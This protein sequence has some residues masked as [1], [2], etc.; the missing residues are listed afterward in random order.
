MFH[1]IRA[2]P[3]YPYFR[4]DPG[5]GAVYF[6]VSETSH[7]IVLPLPHIGKA[8]SNVVSF[9]HGFVSSLP[10]VVLPFHDIVKASHSNVLCIPALVKP[11]RDIVSTFSSTGQ[12]LIS[13]Q[14]IVIMLRELVVMMR[15]HCGSQTSRRYGTLSCAFHAN[16]HAEFQYN[17]GVVTF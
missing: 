16:Q 15:N 6:S 11:F 8:L 14:R 10:D 1:A 9:S 12:P 5:E 7:G 13:A 17:D 4:F 2:I 3:V